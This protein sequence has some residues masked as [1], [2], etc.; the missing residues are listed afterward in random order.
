M[1]VPEAPEPVML[2]IDDE[3]SIRTACA[4]ALTREGYQVHTAAD[5]EAGLELAGELRPDVVFLDL[6][7][8]G[9]GGMA[10][11]EELGLAA[12]E[13]AKVVITAYATASTARGALTG[14][15]DDFL[16][17]PF[18]PDELRLT[19]ARVL[20]HREQARL[21]RLA[22]RE[23]CAVLAGEVLRAS[24]AAAEALAG[25]AELL[26]QGSEAG[27]RLEQVRGVLAELAELARAWE[28]R[29]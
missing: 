9:L 6:K 4:E 10:V 15:A 18:T 13:A 26:E 29:G 2:I 21:A 1:S 16:P 7:M 25:V 3:E 14:G 20:Q 11:L 17:K 8:P 27:R 19:A 24:E 28:R 22:E 12:P 5:G 23:Q